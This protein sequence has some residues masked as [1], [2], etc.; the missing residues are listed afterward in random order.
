MC[1]DAKTRQSMI[2]IT[3]NTI[4]NVEAAIRSDKMLRQVLIKHQKF[5]YVRCITINIEQMRRH[6]T[7][8]VEKQTNLKR[9]NP[10]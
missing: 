10:I 1:M 3:S 6:L 4:A 8:L 9:G 2:A 5:D 7:Q